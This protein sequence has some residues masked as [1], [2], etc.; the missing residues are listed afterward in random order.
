MLDPRQLI[1]QLGLIAGEASVKKPE[2]PL[3]DSGAWPTIIE[4]AKKKAMSQHQA[5]VVSGGA[6]G[7][8]Q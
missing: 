4:T 1:Q 3:A 2:R 8:S 5:P 6:N 7:V